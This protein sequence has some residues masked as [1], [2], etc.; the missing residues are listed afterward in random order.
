MRGTRKKKWKSIQ[1]LNVYSSLDFNVLTEDQL[2]A[3][4]RPGEIIESG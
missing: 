2:S 4:F 1:K 3:E